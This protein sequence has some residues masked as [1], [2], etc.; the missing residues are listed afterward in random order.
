V[1]KEKPERW[2]HAEIN[3]ALAVRYAAPRYAY[4]SE[5]F[6]SVG[7]GRRTDGIAVA[8]WR[9]LGLYIHGF[10]I[11]A[12]R[13]DWLREIKNPGKADGA[14]SN[15]DF[16]WLVTA[17]D[18]VYRA[19]EIPPDWG[20]ITVRGNGLHTVKAAK[21]LNPKATDREFICS[22][23]R[24]AHEKQISPPELQAEYQRGH[25]AGE[26]SIKYQVEIAQAD[27]ARSQESIAKFEKESG[28]Q[29]TGWGAGDIG[30][31]VRCVLERRHRNYKAQLENLLQRSQEITN[32]IQ[33]ELE[34]APNE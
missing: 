22:I 34:G 30:N 23:L 28:V 17:S 3:S 19:D 16:W 31:A 26:Q 7:Y 6:H 5:V 20:L 9:S 21:Q 14:F 2:T 15:C 8:M 24:L 25:N 29:I 10:E 12:S 1:A 4:F 18:E 32:A 27:L 11:K 13:S 33:K